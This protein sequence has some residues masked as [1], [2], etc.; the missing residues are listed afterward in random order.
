MDTAIHKQTPELTSYDLLKTLAVLLMVADHIGYYFYPEQMWW[1]VFGRLCVPVWF[2]LIGYAGTR[3]VPK[4]FWI[5]GAV[6]ALSNVIMGGYVFPLSI[7]FGL[8]LTRLWI[9]GIMHRALRSYEAFSGMVFMMI[10]LAYPAGALVE[11]GTI[12]ALFAMLGFIRA[13]KEAMRIGF[14]PLMGFVA[15]SALAYMLSQLALF[16]TLTGGQFLVFCAGLAFILALLFHF[17]PCAFPVF[18]RMGVPVAPLL[19]VTGRHTLAIYVLH[20]LLFKAVSIALRPDEFEFFGFA[21][22]L[23]GSLSLFLSP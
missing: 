5:G 11:Y 6:L 19:K 14:W 23:P 12:G 7:L 22:M 17:S 1:R 20:I 8:S 13:R 2:F 3:S 4:A 10:L 9:D 16:P 18:P 21:W 15:V